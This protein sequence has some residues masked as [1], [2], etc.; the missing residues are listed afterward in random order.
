MVVALLFASRHINK[1]KN[2]SGF[3][4]GGS[5]STN[6][7]ETTKN[8]NYNDFATNGYKNH[9]LTS[10]FVTLVGLTVEVQKT[11]GHIYE[12][13]LESVSPDLE[14]HLCHASLKSIN[15]ESIENGDSNQHKT[16]MFQFC[17]IVR[18]NAKD[19]DLDFAKRQNL[20]TDTAIS[21]GTGTFVERELVQWQ[22]EEG[23]TVDGAINELDTMGNTG[24]WKFEEMIKQHED[25]YG[26]ESTFDSTMSNYM[27]PLE[28]YDEETRRALE[29]KAERTAREIQG[30][31]K[32]KEFEQADSGQ[33]EEEL[34]SAV[35]RTP[36]NPSSNNMSY[37][38]SPRNADGK[39]MGGGARGGKNA[40]QPP[41]FQHRRSQEDV[42]GGAPRIHHGGSQMQRV[43][44]GSPR[45]P[46]YQQQQHEYSN[47]RSPQNHQS[48]SP[49]NNH[50]HSNHHT[51]HSNHHDPHHKQ[52]P[53]KNQPT[54]GAPH[55]H[56]QNVVVDP[57]IPPPL[58]SYSSVAARNKPSGGMPP[59]PGQ[60]P[61]GVQITNNIGQQ[62]PVNNGR[63]PMKAGPP[64]QAVEPQDISKALPVKQ[65]QL[66]N[67][68]QQYI[69]QA[70]QAVAKSN[71]TPPANKPPVNQM[72]M[73]TGTHQ[74]APKAPTQGP[75]GLSLAAGSAPTPTSNAPKAS[76]SSRLS[77]TNKTGA[78]EHTRMEQMPSTTPRGQG[79]VI[80]FGKI[81]KINEDGRKEPDLNKLK[82]FS[83]SFKLESKTKKTE[84]KT[85]MTA[86]TTHVAVATPSSTTKDS[87][88][89]VEETI[90]K[91]VANVALSAPVPETVLTS[92]PNTKDVSAR[93]SITTTT[94]TT[95]TTTSATRVATSTT[96]TKNVSTTT[97][98][99]STTTTTSVVSS[100]VSA[101][102]TT[103]STTPS[104]LNPGAKSFVFNP[105]VKEFKPKPS[106]TKH[107]NSDHHVTATPHVHHPQ[108]QASHQYIAATPGGV[109]Q[110][111]VVIAAHHQQ[112]AAHHQHAP[113][114]GPQEV[115]QPNQPQQTQ[116]HYITRP[117]YRTQSYPSAGT[118][119][120]MQNNSPILSNPTSVYPSAAAG[121]VQNQPQMFVLNT[122]QYQQQVRLK[123]MQGQQGQPYMTAPHPS[124]IRFI[125]PAQ[126]MPNT[127][128]FHPQDN[129]ATIASS[130]ILQATPHS[131]ATPHQT[132]AASYQQ[133]QTPSSPATGGAGSVVVSQHY[134]PSHHQQYV[135][136]N[137]N[138]NYQH[139]AHSMHSQGNPAAAAAATAVYQQRP[140]VYTAGGQP[141]HQQQHQQP[142]VVIPQPFHH[143]GQGGL[144]QP[145]FQQGN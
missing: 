118:P 69:A 135:M 46:Q 106:P 42:T 32:H 101:T 9:H 130:Y 143:P 100:V 86:S 112:A 51:H 60:Q 78:V 136:N 5:N 119:I 90:T 48:A 53:S 58:K 103:S 110:Q 114:V 80:K 128:N 1:K 71:S 16:L 24:G 124:A 121:Y 132:M 117:V 66:H 41:R 37:P 30:D 144:I 134:V 43:N 39:P 93:P 145:N 64:A 31:T 82:D 83:H 95:T 102:V 65:E 122:Q 67:A 35:H 89:V 21:G 17:D 88:A 52:V 11:D 57:N 104:K 120:E 44:G 8:N 127:A 73:S 20:M 140:S 79:E 107:V 3:G 27:T 4:S 25:N 94:S 74:D 72:P 45:H 38:N 15:G 2:H 109:N 61:Q 99:V 19:V 91:S 29:E 33:G 22:A 68:K 55:N 36:S 47:N 75:P 111:Q 50:H 125:N 23:D 56:S 85:D 141:H 26:T 142:F 34:F 70:K 87:K 139:V 123:M 81:N 13:I 133:H 138:T 105:A 115:I 76:Y 63:P 84:V 49:Y 96:D 10:A 54:G 126:R 129:N 137:Q 131:V 40:Q 108:P 116:P 98:T 113:Q 97:P 12:G 6:W 28:N 14:V 62:P 59:L 7:R 92:K 77:T 18:C